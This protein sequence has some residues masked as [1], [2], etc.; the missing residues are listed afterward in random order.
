[1]AQG[2]G[3]QPLHPIQTLWVP[4]PSHPPEPAGMF[5]RGSPGA[6]VCVAGSEQS[7]GGVTLVAGVAVSRPAAHLQAGCAALHNHTC[8][9]PP[10]RGR[11]L[12]TAPDGA[13][14]L[15]GEGLLF[16]EECFHSAY[17][18]RIHFAV[19]RQAQSC[20]GASFPSAPAALQPGRAQR[21][22][23]ARSRAHRSPG[24]CLMQSAPICTPPFTPL[25]KGCCN[26]SGSC[27]A[28]FKF[29]AQHYRPSL[30]PKD[31]S[32]H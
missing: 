28:P 15:P 27:S 13:A 29:L 31:S 19:T 11:H 25:P 10:H 32:S 2:R 14:A 18:K 1:M 12:V 24:C 5:C 22:W 8:Q 3:H 30:A 23:H 16:W 17:I 21:C 4:A 6:A 20:A 26:P 9:S 7:P